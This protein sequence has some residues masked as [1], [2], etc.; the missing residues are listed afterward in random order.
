MR[1]AKLFAERCLATTGIRTPSAHKPAILTYN[2]DLSSFTTWA[3]IPFCSARHRQACGRTIAHTTEKRLEQAKR[4]TGNGIARARLQNA[5]EIKGTTDVSS[6]HWHGEQQGPEGVVSDK[7]K[8]VASEEIVWSGSHQEAGSR[9][10][11]AEEAANDRDNALISTLISQLA[12][13]KP[14]K[15]TDWPLPPEALFN[16]PLI[17]TLDDSFK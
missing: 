11:T 2:N 17:D 10:E 6:R 16:F 13:S 14:A 9:V 7:L 4:T 12:K 3:T 1:R 15:S 8:G 5:T